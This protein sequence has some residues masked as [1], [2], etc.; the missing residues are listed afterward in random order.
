MAATPPAKP[1]IAHTLLSRAHSPITANTIF[2]EKV[3]RQ[4]LRLRATS[5]HARDRRR[6]RRAG[7]LAEQKRRRKQKPP[8]LSAKL[9]RALGVYE[10][11]KEERKWSIYEPLKDM[12]WTYMK[13][14]LGLKRDTQMLKDEDEGGASNETTRAVPGGSWG[15]VTPVGAGPKITSADFHGA[16]LT[17]VRSRCVSRVGVSGIVIKDTKFTFEIITRTDELKSK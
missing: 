7:K 11:P 8:P 12:W 15:Y 16:E 9:K 14:I 2:R 13:E 5:P 17:V 10:I 4:P 3:L 1:H 6:E